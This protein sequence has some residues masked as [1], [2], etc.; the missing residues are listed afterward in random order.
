[1]ALYCLEQVILDRP[2][3]A[4]TIIYQRDSDMLS[5]AHLWNKGFD[6]A[7]CKQAAKSVAVYISMNCRVCCGASQGKK[8]V[9]QVILML[10][11]DYRTPP[12]LMLLTLFLIT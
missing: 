7:L 10:F 8:S 12:D 9:T 3:S 4:I 6:N 1:M 2:V 11:N 5:K